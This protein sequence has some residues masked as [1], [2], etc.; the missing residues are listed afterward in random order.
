MIILKK[1]RNK[2]AQKDINARW[3]TKNKERHYGYKNHI[4]VDKKSKIITKED[5]E[6]DTPRV[7]LTVKM[8]MLPVLFSPPLTFNF[9]VIKMNTN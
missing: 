9:A 5:I 7:P 1:K 6:H 4:K 2:K 8:L 3:I